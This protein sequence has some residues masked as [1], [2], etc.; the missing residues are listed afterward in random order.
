MTR[1]IEFRAYHPDS[2]M[3]FFDI[4]SEFQEFSYEPTFGC[5]LF[6]DGDLRHVN[7]VEVMQYTGLLD[8]DG[9]KNLEGDV[10]QYEEWH[11]GP[12]EMMADSAAEKAGKPIN[13]MIRCEVVFACGGFRYQEF[14]YNERANAYG[15]MFDRNTAYGEQLSYSDDKI[16]HMEV[17]GNIHENPELLT[18]AK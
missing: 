6:Y 7:D 14:R 3:A 5:V 4:N 2:G 17:I 16:P 18:E 8:R 13:H 9:K 10:L 15:R 11:H 12:V 1:P